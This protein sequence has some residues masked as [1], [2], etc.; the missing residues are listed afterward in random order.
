MSGR[1]ILG[2]YTI[3]SQQFIVIAAVLHEEVLEL[4]KESKFVFADCIEIAT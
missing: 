2:Q 4:Q 1:S 3:G